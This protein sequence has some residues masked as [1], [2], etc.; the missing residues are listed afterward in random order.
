M[1]RMND[2]ALYFLPHEVL[3]KE[4]FGLI[5]KTTK[6]LERKYDALPKIRAVGSLEEGEISRFAALR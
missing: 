1:R 3:F 6:L 5:K 2:S 4:Y